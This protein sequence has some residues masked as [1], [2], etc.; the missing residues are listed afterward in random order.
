MS[1]DGEFLEEA[2]YKVTAVAKKYFR[3]YL[4]KTK[5]S[6]FW[7]K[8]SVN[9]VTHGP[10]WRGGSVSQIFFETI[11]QSSDTC[12]ILAQRFDLH[13]SIFVNKS[14]SRDLSYVEEN[15][16]RLWWL[17]HYVMLEFSLGL[18]SFKECMKVAAA[19]QWEL[20][21]RSW[22]IQS[23]KSTVW[24]LIFHMHIQKFLWFSAHWYR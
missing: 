24:L 18:K 20:S 8:P 5:F 15:L 4:S 7:L 2:F 14:Q 22:A 19:G 1:S 10:G 17:C 21:S 11:R 12:C 16:S 6:C 23:N 3:F 13:N 9:T